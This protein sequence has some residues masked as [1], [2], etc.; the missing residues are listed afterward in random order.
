MYVFC[1]NPLT[2]SS[3]LVLASSSRG[4]SVN[5]PLGL[6]FQGPGVRTWHRR[7]PVRRVFVRSDERFSAGLLLGGQCSGIAKVSIR[8]LGSK[9]WTGL[10]ANPTP[11]GVLTAKKGPTPWG[12]VATPDTSGRWSPGVAP[13]L[14]GRGF[15][16]GTRI[17]AWIR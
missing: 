2:M 17:F 12:P 8:A 16:F 5:Q 6:P 4:T 11:W 1:M 3:C 10:N 15:P 7:K 13:E 9:A 14:W